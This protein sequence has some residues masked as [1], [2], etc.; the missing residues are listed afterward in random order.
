MSL[1]ILSSQRHMV[2]LSGMCEQDLWV[3]FRLHWWQR[4]I[5]LHCCRDEWCL[6]RRRLCDIN[7]LVVVSDVELLKM[8]PHV[9]GLGL[10]GH[11]TVEVELVRVDD[12]SIYFH[13]AM[14]LQC[15]FNCMVK[16]WDS[17]IFG[18]LKSLC[19]MII[20]KEFVPQSFSVQY[21]N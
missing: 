19:R 15:S 16:V 10:W 20:R 3:V 14:L 4:F 13:L 9:V 6:V 2:Q 7:Y 21:G 11:V 8:S 17:S 18:G 5:V 1:L 12:I